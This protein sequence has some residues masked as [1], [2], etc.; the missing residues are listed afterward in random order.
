[1]KSLQERIAECMNIRRQIESLGILVCPE[2][3][4]TLSQHMNAFI[5]N[6]TSQTFNIRAT[7]MV[8]LKI[9]LTCNDKK[10]SGVYFIKS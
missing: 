10:Q 9:V 7:N 5:S 3:S 8:T 4:K 1:M 2:I 6:E